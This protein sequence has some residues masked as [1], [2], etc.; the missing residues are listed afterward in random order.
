MLLGMLTSFLSLVGAAGTTVSVGG[1]V[2]LVAYIGKQSIE[3]IEYEADG[4][5]NIYKLDEYL[6]I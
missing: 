5:K 1:A 2:K 6:S 4:K 3:Y